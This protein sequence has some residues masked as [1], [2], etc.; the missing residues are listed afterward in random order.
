M[1]AAAQA[2]QQGEVRGRG[3]RTASISELIDI[4]ALEPD[5]LIVTGDGTY[6]RVIDCDFVPNPITADPGQIT[7]IEEGWAAVFAA[8]PDH[9]GLSLYAQ[10]DP[11]A[12][13]DAM[14]ADTERVQRAITDDL[15]ADPPRTDLAR[16]RRRLLH[17]QRQSVSV[18]AGAEQPAV[19][20]RYWVAVPWRPAIGLKERFKDACSPP[21]S[22]HRTSWEA[23]QRAARDSLQYTLQIAG[24]LTG[25]GIDP[26]LMGPVEI[27]AGLWERLHPAARTLPNFELF[28][29]V[30]RIVQASTPDQAAAHRHSILDAICAGAEPV[31]IDATDRRWLRHRDGTFEET[32]HLGTVPQDTSPW[33]LA[34]LLQVPL[35]T[36]VAVHVRVGD[37]SRT[38]LT[39]RRRWA[40]LR[41]AV[42]YKQRRG[43]LI[44]SD[45]QDAVDE[46]ELLDRELRATVAATVYDVCTYVS[47]RQPDGD[48]T[49]FGER[50]KKTATAFQSLTDARVLRGAFLNV[51]AYPCTLPIAVDP[52]KATRRYAHRNIA[53]C[54][55]LITAAC[56]SPDGLMLGFSD[57]GGTLERVDPY[58]PAF[59]TY[60]T[61][62]I[63]KGGAGKTVMVNKLLLAAIAQ[64]MRGFIIDRSTIQS[65]DG[66][67]QGHYDPLL[68][69][70]P[71]SARVHVGSAGTDVVCPWDVADLKRVPSAKVELLLALHAL[72]IGNLHGE[73]RRLT[74]QEEGPLTTAIA[75]VYARCAKTGERPCET[76]L[77]AE[78][79]AL[80]TASRHGSVAATIHSLIARL[81]P[82]IQGGPLAHIADWPTTVAPDRPL[83]LFDIA[84]APDRLAPALI[85]TI[86]DH[87]EHAI[88]QT[89]SQYVHGDLQDTGVWAGRPFLVIEE[90]WKLTA[91]AASGAWINE[92]ARRSRH[93]ELW[94]LWATQFSKDADNEQGRALLENSSIRLLFRNNR[95]DLQFAREPLGLTD[96]DI[97]AI[98]SLRTRPGLYSTVYLQSERG[99]GQVRSILGA[100]EYWICSNHPRHDQPAR[101][102]A[103]HDAGGDPWKALR[104]LCTPGWQQHYHDHNGGA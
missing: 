102:A 55:P 98:C 77:V 50:V 11:I 49:A 59:Q 39:Q 81:T 38:R 17:A 91:S 23:H 66:R 88:Q 65:G 96:T 80:A 28:E 21:R 78:L 70:V 75:A 57:P 94:L 63:G 99:R 82:Y 1:T 58:D 8:I 84:G 48:A 83:T 67:V 27:L 2:R 43:Q 4:H 41:A 97:D 30:A 36:T 14:R 15:A 62:L 9:Q 85:L 40:R 53:H 7:A 52:L 104:L 19:Q 26:Y 10:V 42:S 51:S 18:A 24:L 73:Q 61:I 71:G 92:Y 101:H 95:R 93:W 13:D 35:S 90:G 44:G 3:P 31:G 76:L 20:A 89:R 60:V 46:A 79:E 86:V 25:L 68:S 33:W 64:G 69:L 100:L 16:T 74:A 5:G 54:S 45:E 87:I 32:L 12:I 56:G 72:L 103:L 34:H 29:R 37:R 6:V 47:F 22:E